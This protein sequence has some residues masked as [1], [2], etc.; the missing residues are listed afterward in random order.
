MWRIFISLINSDHKFNVSLFRFVV[1]G[2]LMNLCYF[3]LYL[4]FVY[5][6]SSVF[7]AALASY[8]FVLPA[9]YF[10]SSRWTFDSQNRPAF[11]KGLIYFSAVYLSSGVIMAAIIGLLTNLGVDYRLSWC[12]G[13][14]YAASHN[15]LLSKYLVFNE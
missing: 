11:G 3:L 2:L 9:T 4:G 14:F 12:F 10:M 5:L 1:V 13:T 7:L 8:F 6:Y 15:F